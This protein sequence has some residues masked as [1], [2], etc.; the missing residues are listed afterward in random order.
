MSISDSTL[1]NV[2]QLNIWEHVDYPE[3]VMILYDDQNPVPDAP[4]LSQKWRIYYTFS[5]YNPLSVPYPSGTQLFRARH[6]N[7]Y[8]YELIDIVPVQ[9]VFHVDDPGTYFVAY[10]H[11]FDGTTRLPFGGKYIFVRNGKKR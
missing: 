7:Q 3:R 6:S 5:A 8:P 10:A 4:S 9:D 2:I 1:T 11:P